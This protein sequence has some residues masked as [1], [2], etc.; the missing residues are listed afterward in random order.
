MSRPRRRERIIVLKW[1]LLVYLIL[2]VPGW[3]F[4]LGLCKVSS[5]ADEDTARLFAEIKAQKAQEEQD[6]E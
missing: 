1:I 6:K 5:G 4:I 3:L 2:A